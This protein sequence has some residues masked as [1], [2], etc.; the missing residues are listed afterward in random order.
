MYKRGELSGYGCTTAQVELRKWTSV[1]PCGQACTSTTY[2][3][4]KG[5]DGT[6][7]TYPMDAKDSY[8]SAKN[9]AASKKIKQDKAGSAFKAPG[10]SG[11]F[12]LEFTK[13]GPHASPPLLSST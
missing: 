9:V 1:R 6:V 5:T 8:K 12:Y 4:G 10:H 7:Y 3:G 13:A 2:G 11:N